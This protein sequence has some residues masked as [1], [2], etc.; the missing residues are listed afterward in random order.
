MIIARIAYRTSHL[1]IQRFEATLFLYVRRRQFVRVD[2]EG[3]AFH[4]DRFGSQQRVDHQ[5]T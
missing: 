5:Q 4:I 3:R 2:V 1:G